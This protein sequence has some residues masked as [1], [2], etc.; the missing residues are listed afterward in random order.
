MI[1]ENHSTDDDIFEYYKELEQDPKIR[2][3]T[4]TDEFNYA[5]VNNFAVK[6]SKGDYLLLLNN[7]TEVITPSWIEELLMYAQRDDVGVV[8]AKLYFSDETIESSEKSIC[9]HNNA[10]V[11]TFRNFPKTSFGYGNRLS[12]VTNCSLLIGACI[13]SSREKYLEVGGL[14]E[15]FKIWYNDTD[16]CLKLIE[17]NYVVVWNPFSELFHY[18]SVS[19]NIIEQSTKNDITNKERIIFFNKWNHYIEKYYNQNLMLTSFSYDF[20]IKNS[21]LEW[22]LQVLKQQARKLQEAKIALKQLQHSKSYRVGHMI[23]YPLS[24]PLKIFRLIRDYNL[25]KKS[26]LF[27]SEYYLANN[28]DVRNAKINPIMH[29]LKFG[30]KEGRNP[31]ADFDSKAYLDSRPDVKVAGICPLVHYLK[32]GKR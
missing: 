16:Y 13:M 17:K 26:G 28:E 4:F 23:I 22:Q 14:D 25:L 27:D 10:D 12:I 19:I 1:V 31:S 9:L 24:I 21:S 11:P 29:Y 18:E 6:E 5:A 2:I 30:W 20:S 8:G 3:L 7:D 32:F 15:Q